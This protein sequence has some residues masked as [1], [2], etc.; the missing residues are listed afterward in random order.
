MITKINRYYFFQKTT[1]TI[2]WTSIYP[3]YSDMIFIGQSDNPNTK[4][5][6]QIFMRKEKCLTGC[7][8]K[9]YTEA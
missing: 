2:Y 1:K 4:V 8:I 6:A 9:E 7:K 5:A 3:Q